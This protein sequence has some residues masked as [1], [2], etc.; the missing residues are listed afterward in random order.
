MTAN[1]ARTKALDVNTNAVTSQYMKVQNIIS[2]EAAKGNYECW[3]YEVLK[4]DVRKKLEEEGFIVG[5]QQM[6][7]GN[8]TMVKISWLTP[9][10]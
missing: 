3:F 4:T 2:Q 7:R 1:E 6:D 8:D 5:S 9:N 10:K